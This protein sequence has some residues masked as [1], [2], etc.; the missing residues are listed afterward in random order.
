MKNGGTLIR[1]F[2]LILVAIIF[3]GAIANW[4]LGKA[5]RDESW[6]ENKKEF[7]EHKEDAH[8]GKTDKDCAYCTSFKKQEKQHDRNEIQY[9]VNAIMNFATY[10]TFCGMMYGF[11]ALI[12][13][14]STKTTVAAAVAAAAPAPVRTPAPAPAPAPKAPA[15]TFCPKCGAKQQE[16]ARFCP[17]CGNAIE[18]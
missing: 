5:S 13:S 10:A 2:A 16:G 3:A 8:D 6:K 17:A 9:V 7:T 1:I 4:A 18:Q 12:E 14:K 15:A 11:G